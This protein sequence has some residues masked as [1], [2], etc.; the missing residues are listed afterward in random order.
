MVGDQLSE[1]SLIG[2]PT[3]GN[4]VS[5]EYTADLEVLAG[6]VIWTYCIKY[7]VVSLMKGGSFRN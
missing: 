2:Y 7:V 6:V 5:T 1:S 3:V 4:F